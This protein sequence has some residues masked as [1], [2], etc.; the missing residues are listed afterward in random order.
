M[1]RRLR[2]AWRL[3]GAMQRFEDCLRMDDTPDEACIK[4]DREQMAFTVD[5]NGRKETGW[6]LLRAIEKRMDIR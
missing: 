6:P 2:D 1:F 4:F 5:W 3:A